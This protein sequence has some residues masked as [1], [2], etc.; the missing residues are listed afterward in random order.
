MSD[1]L[2]WGPISISIV[3]F[4]LA[5][6]LHSQDEETSATQLM[7][8]PPPVEGV[9]SLGVYDSRGK[10]VRILKKAA[11]IDSFKSGLNGLFIDW[12]KNDQD[13]KPVPNGKYFARGVMI[14][15]VKIAGV[16]F[17]LNDWVGD[18][19]TPRPRIRQEIFS[20]QG[21]VAIYVLGLYRSL[22]HTVLI[23]RFR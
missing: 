9:I 23:R 19:N 10:L 13:G 3:L 8:V 6:P 18:P 4:L 14:G 5:L 7:F 2:R 11:N 15:D 17:H 20:T 22:C 1:C 16:A 21:K 12:D